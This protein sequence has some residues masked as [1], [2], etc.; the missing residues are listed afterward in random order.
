M[1]LFLVE[2]ARR[3]ERRA[4]IASVGRLR[5]RPAAFI[6]GNLRIRTES[7][8]ESINEKP[9]NPIKRRRYFFRHISPVTRLFKAARKTNAYGA[10][11]N[12]HALR[13]SSVD[14]DC[15]CSYCCRRRELDGLFPGAQ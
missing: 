9:E 1:H 11:H 8:R 2:D 12:P 15:A 10:R 7:L 5:A 14:N 4:A 13:F 3:I 6:F